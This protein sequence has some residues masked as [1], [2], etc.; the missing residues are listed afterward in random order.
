MLGLG[1]PPRPPSGVLI[2]P[3]SLGLYTRLPS[4]FVPISIDDWSSPRTLAAI[5]LLRERCC[6]SYLSYGTVPYIHALVARLGQNGQSPAGSA[7]CKLKVYITTSQ[8]QCVWL[9]VAAWLPVPFR[10]AKRGDGAVIPPQSEFVRR[11]PSGIRDSKYTRTTVC[12]W[13]AVSP[14][15][16][17][18]DAMTGGASWPAMVSPPRSAPTPLRPQSVAASGHRAR[19]DLGLLVGCRLLA[20]HAVRPSRERGTEEME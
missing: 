16:L 3:R 17:P 6:T 10:D 19:G 12:T 2:T 1:A 15:S 5:H 14:H 4:P 20:S 11:A 18:L 7:V 8:P 9:P 13:P